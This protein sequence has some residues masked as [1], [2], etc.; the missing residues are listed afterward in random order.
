MSTFLTVSR[1]CLELFR[2]TLA[3]ALWWLASHAL[4]GFWGWLCALLAQ[5]GLHA[6]LS[7]GLSHLLTLASAVVGAR[8]AY[9]FWYQYGWLKSFLFVVPEAA[10]NLPDKLLGRAFPEPQ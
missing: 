3:F 10:Q 1:W 9:W 8:I 6:D 4:L 2:A 5:K 7:T